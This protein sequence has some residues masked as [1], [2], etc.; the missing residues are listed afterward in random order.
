MAVVLPTYLLIYT[1]SYYVAFLL[2]CEFTIPPEVFDWF[3]FTLPVV[4]GIKFG[5]CAATGEWRRTFRYASLHD[6]QWVVIGATLSAAAIY[7]ANLTIFPWAGYPVPRSV[8]VIDWVFAIAGCAA[9]RMSSRLYVESIRPLVRGAHTNRALVFGDNVEAVGILR[10]AQSGL[11][12]FRVVG[13]VGD[14]PRKQRALIAGVR[15]FSRPSDWGKLTRKTRARHV[16]VPGSVGGKELREI[17]RQC[18]ENDVTV[19]VIPGVNEIVDG[20]FRLTVREVTINDLLRREPAQLDMASIREYLGGQRVLVTGAA[21]SIGSELCRQILALEPERLTLVDQSEYAMFRFEQELQEL[22]EREPARTRLDFVIADVVDRGSMAR[23]FREQRP[24]IVFHAAAYKHVPLMEQNAR[25][26]VRNNVG[27]ARTIADLAAELP[28][29]RFVLISTDKAVRPTSVMGAT[30]L[31]AEKYVQSISDRSPARFVTVRFGNVL[32]SAGSVVPT[33]RRQIERGGPVTVTHPEMTRFFMTIPEA[34][35]LVLQAGAIGGGGDIMILEMGE[36][37]KIVDLAKDMIALSGL[38]PKEDIDIV[39]TGVRPG[40]KLYEELFYLSEEGTKQVH[41]K[42][43]CAQRDPSRLVR[44]ADD[45]AALL[46]AVE[47][48]RADVAA[49]LREVVARYV[50]AENWGTEPIRHA[51]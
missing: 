33:F 4:V 47:D 18:R 50:A 8:I 14:G 43:F 17:T 10:A 37:V 49:A 40:E 22:A 38:R 3:R 26:A 12:E 35:Q 46:R 44:A 39:F 9:L 24:Q 51:A 7:L 23:L 36:P 32:G 5:V 30:K 29:E 42:I 21:G 27:G 13:L 1:A 2:R 34:V 25:E 16:L 6:M 45:V 31:V 20:R 11:A 28:V 48:P 15:V 19:H 41:D